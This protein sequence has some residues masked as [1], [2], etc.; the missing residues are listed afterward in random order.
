MEQEAEHGE[1]K[2]QV[3][4]LKVGQIKQCI[5]NP[6]WQQQTWTRLE[7][8]G[9]LARRCSELGPK[10]KQKIRIDQSWRFYG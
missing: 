1:E 8:A 2:K 6:K 5:S 7:G 9:I 3:K 10:A 4:G